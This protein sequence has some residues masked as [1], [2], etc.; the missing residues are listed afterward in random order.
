MSDTER[1]IVPYRTYGLILFLLLILTSITVLVTQIELST[2]STVVALT[3][4]GLKTSLV[5]AIFMHLKF[6][7]PIYRIMAVAII[8]LLGVFNMKKPSSTITAAAFAGTAV[9]LIWGLIDT[10]TAIQVGAML[11]SASTAFVAA[12]F[13]FFKKE[14]VLK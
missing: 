6:D 10:F 9:T 3:L 4:A 12:A 11:V 5:L 2:W 13:G 1:H 14:T 8:I 7:Q